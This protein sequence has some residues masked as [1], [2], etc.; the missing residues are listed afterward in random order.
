MMAAK[1]K[2]AC[3]G[4]NGHQI[5][6]QLKDHPRAE[7]TAVAEITR[8]QVEERLG[9]EIAG[10]VRIAPHL[11]ALLTDPEVD[12]ISLC[13]PRRVEQFDH[14]IE[15]LR[16]GKH[17]LA[18]KPAAFTVDELD[19]LHH[20][21]GKSRAQFRQMGA[22]GHEAT[23]TAI[24]KLVDAGRLGEVVHVC[25]LKSYPHHDGRPQDRGVDGGLIRQAGIHGVRFM[26]RATGLRA[27][28]V[29]ALD[30]THGDPKHGLLQMAASV[31]LQFDNGAVGVLACNYLNPRGIGY[32]G[33]DQLRVHGTGGMV[34]AVDG[35]T[36]CRMVLGAG[37]PE[38]IPDV[39][40]SYPDFFDAYVDHLLD[41]TPMPY[42]PEEDL[43]AL[44][45]V[46]RAQD[47]VDNRSILQV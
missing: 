30:T 1:L 44:R 3:Y 35:F 4:L 17:V 41:G 26:Q 13:S 31:A 37:T 39:P 2:V 34:E 14:A 45:T 21:M 36:R 11:D 20:V 43:Y 25:A 8:G 27:V 5:L 18:E 33:N 23:L 38:P 15:C 28:R 10:R 24:R 6:G 29:C 22:C 42:D 7:L 47:A 16:S 46:I 9:A 12:L 40:A 19:E 32:W